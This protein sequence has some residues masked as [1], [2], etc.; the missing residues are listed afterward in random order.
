MKIIDNNNKC[1]ETNHN[2]INDPKL[3]LFS[4]CKLYFD[5]I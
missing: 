1:G 3:A 5:F 2:A 4:S